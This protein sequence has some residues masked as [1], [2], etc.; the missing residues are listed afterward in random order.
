MLDSFIGN[1]IFS[2]SLLYDYMEVSKKELQRTVTE[3][4]VFLNVA[5]VLG[6][7]VA[8]ITSTALSIYSNCVGVFLI[9]FQR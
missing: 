8:Q 3:C 9:K 5:L 4:T 7:E 2:N 1:T 6:H